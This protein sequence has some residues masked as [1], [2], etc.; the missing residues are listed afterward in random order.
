MFSNITTPNPVEESSTI[1]SALT[2]VIL[3]HRG[4]TLELSLGSSLGSL[5]LG[6]QLGL[7]SEGLPEVTLSTLSLITIGICNVFGTLQSSGLVGVWVSR[8]QLPH[9]CRGGS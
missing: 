7:V 3:V 8:C 1:L 4:D 2:L 5:G 6:D 9:D